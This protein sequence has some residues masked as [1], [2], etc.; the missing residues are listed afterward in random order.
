MSS[1]VL[2]EHVYVSVCVCVVH[3]ALR[4]VGLGVSRKPSHFDAHLCS[5]AV[6]RE[7][8]SLLVRG[9]L[10]RFLGTDLYGPGRGGGAG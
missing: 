8:F 3:P 9:G 6:V 5:T 10:C 4:E 7:V 1:A 2:V